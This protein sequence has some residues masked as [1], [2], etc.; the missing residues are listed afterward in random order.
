M[1]FN[2]DEFIEKEFDKKFCIRE[3][4]SF[5]L[6]LYSSSDY[7]TEAVR[8]N[9][10]LTSV[11]NFINNYRNSLST[12]IYKSCKF[13][14]KAFLIQV[15]NHES[16]DALAIQFVSYDKL[17]DN[18]KNEIEKVPALIKLKQ[19]PVANLGLIRPGVVAGKVK[20]A[21][22]GIIL[23][24]RDLT[25]CEFSVDT[26]TRCWK[27]YEVRPENGSPEPEKTK[28]EYCVYDEANKMYLYTEKWVKFIIAKMKKAGEY[29]SLYC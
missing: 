11:L 6:Q 20:K 8:K 15:A 10:S 24:K 28:S 29:E 21:L 2:F 19:V 26:H 9:K 12:D 5:S 4:L 25:D 22:K 16:K 7:H 27:K 18:V 13:A 14:F 1:L 3:C 17:P 23:K